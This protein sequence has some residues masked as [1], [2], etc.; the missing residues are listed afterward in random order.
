MQTPSEHGRVQDADGFMVFGEITPSKPAK[1]AAIWG[2]LS[3][4]V[5]P[6]GTAPQKCACPQDTEQPV[7]IQV[8]SMVVGPLWDTEMDR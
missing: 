4:P 2:G 3:L 5:R 7:A 8:G 1:V 6:L